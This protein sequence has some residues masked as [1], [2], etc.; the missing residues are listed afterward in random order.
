VSI[1][2]DLLKEL[3]HAGQ[4]EEPDLFEIGAIQQD[5]EHELLRYR[6]ELRAA[7]AGR[8]SKAQHPG[9]DAEEQ[10]LLFADTADIDRELA[11]VEDLLRH[12]ARY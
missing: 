9:S 10:L 1:V 12:V 5:L 11:H 2:E 8:E 4:R 7:K 3:H 6:D